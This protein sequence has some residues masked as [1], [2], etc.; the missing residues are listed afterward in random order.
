MTLSCNPTEPG[1]VATRCFFVQLAGSRKD[2]GRSGRGRGLLQEQLLWASC[3]ALHVENV[4]QGL[5]MELVSQVGECSDILELENLWFEP[6]GFHPHHRTISWLC[7]GPLTLPRP[8]KCPKHV[9][10]PQG[11]PEPKMEN[12]KGGSL[13]CAKVVKEIPG[14][15]LWFGVMRKKRAV[16]RSI[17]ADR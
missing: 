7:L 4:F 13:G 10:Y 5:R 1:G 11:C 17:H 15:E 16:P 2:R 3:R 8:E 9:S 12:H 14:T 6:S